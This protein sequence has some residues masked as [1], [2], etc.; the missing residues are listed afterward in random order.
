MKLKF[1]YADG[2]KHP[3]VG[4]VYHQCQQVIGG[5]ETARYQRYL[6]NTLSGLAQN[7]EDCVRILSLIEKIESRAETEI[8]VEGNDI[9]LT[10]TSTGV[11]VDITINDDWMG[12]P[13]G[14]FQLRELKSAISGWQRFL[15]LP[16]SFDSIVEV[17]L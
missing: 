2:G 16:E 17:E 7:P 11:Q 15:G 12:Q 8:E 9:G 1:Y 14:K 5:G 3:I 13:E 10:I 6:A 4:Q